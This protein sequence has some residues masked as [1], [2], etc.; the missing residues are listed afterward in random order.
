MAQLIAAAR[1]RETPGAE[2]PRAETP[3]A[4]R[5]EQLPDLGRSADVGRDQGLER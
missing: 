1:R 5:Y 2:S 4:L 3:D